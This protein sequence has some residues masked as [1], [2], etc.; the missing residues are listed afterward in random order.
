MTTPGACELHP[1]HEVAAHCGNC[2]KGICQECIREHGYY[3]SAACLQAGRQELT[4]AD[5]RQSSETFAQF[6]RGMK[7]LRRAGWVLVVL[8]L[9]SVGYFCW[10]VFLNPAG[11]LQ[12]RWTAEGAEEH[13]DLGILGHQDG[14]IYVR[15]RGG[16]AVLDAASG[17]AVATFE[18][19]AFKDPE[20]GLNIV[21]RLR[22]V[23]LCHDGILAF[24]AKSL[25]H[26][27]L[28]GALK[29]K[30]AWPDRVQEFAVTPDHRFLCVLRTEQ[31]DPGSW[32]LRHRLACLNL[33][34]GAE[35]WSRA[36]REN[37][38]VGKVLA[39]T[40]GIAVLI[41]KADKEAKTV[42]YTI[43]FFSPESDKPLWTK[44][45][46]GEPDWGPAAWEDALFYAVN[47]QVHALTAK[48]VPKWK[49]ANGAAR[50]IALPDVDE[51]DIDYFVVDGLLGVALDG[52]GLCYDLQTGKGLWKMR[53]DFNEDDMIAGAQRLYVHGMVKK[54]G[55]TVDLTKMPGFNQDPDLIR[56]SGLDR[57][58]LGK[59][60]PTLICIDRRT[61]DLLW[62]EEGVFGT[63]L[64]DDQRLVEVY[65]TGTDSVLG[66]LRQDVDTIIRRRRLKDGSIFHTRTHKKLSLGSS[67]LV[68][69][70]LVGRTAEAGD[71]PEELVFSVVGFNV[72]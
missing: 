52:A 13:E 19:P 45:L 2:H 12:W 49:D 24:G 23:R 65:N 15:N 62:R 33:E 50:T 58:S 48:G 61:G 51:D 37:W 70:R 53:L 17:A 38:K 16:I 40:R 26:V 63:I 68:G 59:A 42:A 25:R 22:K 43:A 18:M 27:G 7:V 44:T 66:V 39:T 6:E 14:K 29:G 34:T 60:S 3:C 32:R 64:G 21:E 36:L 67:L 9:A 41:A 71:E 1:D 31:T 8:A 56:E 11:R 28:D 72:E 54:E 55:K 5:R 35:M 46:A 47:Q 10:G 20:S 69:G 4:A 57:M 30:V